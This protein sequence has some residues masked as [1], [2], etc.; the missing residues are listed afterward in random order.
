MVDGIYEQISAVIEA[1]NVAYIK[2]DMNRHLTDIYSA[3]MQV[4]NQGVILHKYVL[5]VYDFL[6]RLLARF[7]ELL[8]E[9]CAGG[10]GRFDA[11]MLYYTPQIWCS[12]NTDAIER[13]KIQYGTSFGY[14]ISAVGSHVSAVPN[15]QTGRTTNIHT[16]GIVAMAGS[17]GYE[18]DLNLITE[19]E[20]VIVRKQIADYKKFWNVIQNGAYY[21]LTNP[22]E[23]KEYAAWQFVNDNETLLNV[24]TLSTSCNSAAEY[25]RLKGLDPKAVYVVQDTETQKAYTGA[26][27]MNA[28]LPIPR[29]SDEYQGWQVYLQKQ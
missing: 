10:G 28:G 4:Q 3:T 22:F 27:L 2:M 8:I 7:P 23:K 17:F 13:I 15:H 6:E 29:M 1:T 25:V 16:R 21:R 11:G 12:D 18:L 14:P 19:E 20:K 24:V 9:G 5:G 26:A